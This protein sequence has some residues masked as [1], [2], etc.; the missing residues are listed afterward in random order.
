MPDASAYHDILVT[1]EAPAAI[2]TLN[3]PNVLNALRSSLLTEVSRALTAT[4]GDPAVRAIVITGA[5]EKAFAAGADIAELNALPRAGHGADQ[6]RL[7]KPSRERSS[8]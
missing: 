8:A 5:G 2:I 1:V 6:A 3:R 4:R 7:G